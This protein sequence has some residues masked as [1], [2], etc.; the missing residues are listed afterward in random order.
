M[1]YVVRQKEAPFH[2]LN[3]LPIKVWI[4]WCSPFYLLDRYW[5]KEERT[6]YSCC[7]S[8]LPSC[9]LIWTSPQKPR[10]VSIL[11]CWEHSFQSPWFLGSTPDVS[12]VAKGLTAWTPQSLWKWKPL[13][14]RCLNLTNTANAQWSLDEFL[15]QRLV[16]HS[17][18]TQCFEWTH[19]RWATVGSTYQSNESDFMSF[20]IVTCV[21]SKFLP[22]L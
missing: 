19:V 11:L 4:N 6:G 2:R 1:F 5:R 9:R 12:V 8:V 16:V 17:G 13:S 7:P 20:V 22:L 3:L 10:V 15:L 14:R 21:H 18:G